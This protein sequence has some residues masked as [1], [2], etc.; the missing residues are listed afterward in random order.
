LTELVGG[1]KYDEERNP[2]RAVGKPPELVLLFMA[3]HKPPDDRQ[4][5]WRQLFAP[6]IEVKGEE[7][8]VGRC[9]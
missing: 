6:P 8:V 5:S 4:P 7:L 1:W 3:I 2:V 9:E